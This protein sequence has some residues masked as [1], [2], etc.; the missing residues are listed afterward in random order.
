MRSLY[1]YGK[2]YL[3]IS[4]ERKQTGMEDL[5]VALSRDYFLGLSGQ[6]NQELPIN[7]FCR[8]ILILFS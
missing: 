1:Y 5:F 8:D 4:K 2:A 7:V 3:F 6:R